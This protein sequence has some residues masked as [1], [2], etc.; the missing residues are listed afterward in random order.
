MD[1]TPIILAVDDASANLTLCRGILCDEYDVR[2]AKSGR[3]ALAALS[4][5]RPDVILLDIEMPD[6]SGFEVMEAIN[7]KADYSDI[8]VI[9]VTSHATEKLVVKAVEHGAFSYIVK[10]FDAEV[11]HEKIRLALQAK[12]KWATTAGD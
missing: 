7:K 2:L 11:L 4:K 1:K 5:M 9:F 10:P 8:P 12:I 3:M 6:M